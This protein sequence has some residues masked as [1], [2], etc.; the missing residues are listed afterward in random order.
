MPP[1]QNSRRKENFTVDDVAAIIAVLNDK[2]VRLQRDI[3][4]L[5]EIELERDHYGA[6]VVTSSR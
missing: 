6:S 5:K 4:A 3:R 2:V 1:T